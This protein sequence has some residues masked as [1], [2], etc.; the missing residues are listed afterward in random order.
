MT[1]FKLSLPDVTFEIEGET[2]FVEDLYKTISRDLEPMLIAATAGEP[3]DLPPLKQETSTSRKNSQSIRYTWVYHCTALFNKVYVTENN[4]ISNSV[5]GR[6]IDVDRV[7]RISID[8]DN[9]RSIFSSLFDDNR[10]LW[11]E[12]TEEGRQLLR[13]TLENKPDTTA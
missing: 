6:F 4:I 8:Q 1:R 12:F 11:A 9:G 5:I 3:I 2:T 7:R 10:T 13:K